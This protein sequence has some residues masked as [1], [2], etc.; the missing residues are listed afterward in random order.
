MTSPSLSRVS[1]CGAESRMLRWRT[2]VTSTWKRAGSS[3]CSVL[4]AA[5]DQEN[6]TEFGEVPRLL[7]IGYEADRV[8]PDDD[9][10]EKLAEQRRQLQN[11]KNR[12]DY[13]GRGKQQ[14]H[15]FQDS[16]AHGV[17]HAEK[18]GRAN[19]STAFFAC[20][21]GRQVP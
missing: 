6:D 1:G 10:D 21:S 15:K 5:R 20:R 17:A 7:V 3:S 11:P 13:D 14:E 2:A 16:E 18:S 8:R 19:S 9:A 12:H 4:P